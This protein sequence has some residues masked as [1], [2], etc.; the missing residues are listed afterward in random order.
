LLH[1]LLVHL[2][3]C[4]LIPLRLRQCGLIRCVTLGCG[5]T[6]GVNLISTL[7]GLVM[8]LLLLM[9]QS[10]PSMGLCLH[11]RHLLRGELLAT[12]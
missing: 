10:H 7:L 3:L 8:I 5:L 4:H 2:R 6:A 9:L 12:I 11:V 1:S